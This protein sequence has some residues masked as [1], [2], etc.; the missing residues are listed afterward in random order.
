MTVFDYAVLGIVGLSVLVSLF[1]GA[2]REIMA[3][4]SWIG[5]FLFALHFAPM[6]SVL[7][8][9]SVAHPWLRS[10]PA[11]GAL[12]L[13]SLILFGLM[14]MALSRV[15]RNAGLGSWDRMMGVVFGLVRGLLILIGLVLVAG[16]TPLPRE[17]AWRNAV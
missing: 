2:I 15:V 8:P 3:L 6:L 16:M 7:L 1:R 13:V 10:C 11:F 9:A 5:G 4:L 14:T 12:M 17:P